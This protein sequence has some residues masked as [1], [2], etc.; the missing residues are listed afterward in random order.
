MGTQS[1]ILAWRIPWTEEPGRLQ[2]IG[3][4]RVKPNW[5]NPTVACTHA[6]VFLIVTTWWGGGGEQH[7]WHLVGASQRCC[8]TRYNAQTC[9]PTTKSQGS[10]WYWCCSMTTL[11]L[12]DLGPKLN[13][14]LLVCSF[15]TSQ[16]GVAVAHHSPCSPRCPLSLRG[17]LQSILTTWVQR[18][19]VRNAGSSLTLWRQLS[20]E[21]WRMMGPLGSHSWVITAVGRHRDAGK[22]SLWI[23]TPL[24]VQK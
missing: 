12:A 10:Q 23:S 2:S 18:C 8:Y 4:Q 7:S 20:S 22:I 3:T 16:V 14:L 5:S 15:P 13:I 1:S 19:R 21:A 9:S 17:L 11:T 24:A 6:E